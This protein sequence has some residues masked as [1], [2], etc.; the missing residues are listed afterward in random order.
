M[1]M[2]SELAKAETKLHGLQWTR[3]ATGERLDYICER[4]SRLSS[5][6]SAASIMLYDHCKATSCFLL[7]VYLSD[8]AVLTFDDE[9]SLIWVIHFS[10]FNMTLY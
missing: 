4:N 10:A 7:V 8:P 1:D 3:Y 2:A 9:V 6:V 5:A